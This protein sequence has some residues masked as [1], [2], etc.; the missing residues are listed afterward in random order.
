MEATWNIGDFKPFCRPE[1][2]GQSPGSFALTVS[3]AG[4]WMHM[5]DKK[6]ISVC[7]MH[8][9]SIWFFSAPCRRTSHDVQDRI[10]VG[11]FQAFQL[12]RKVDDNDLFVQVFSTQ[13]N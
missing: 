3:I 1:D 9:K 7:I 6:M 12:Q 8:S 10:Q 13:G 11:Q 2:S 5:A 4:N